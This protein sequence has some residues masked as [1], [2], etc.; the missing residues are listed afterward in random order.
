MGLRYSLAGIIKKSGGFPGLHP[1]G[2]KSR[3][4]SAYKIGT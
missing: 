3:G 1:L 2:A 4:A